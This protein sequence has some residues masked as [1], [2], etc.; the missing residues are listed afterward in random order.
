MLH[1][2]AK[3]L[4]ILRNQRFRRA[5]LGHGVKAGIEFAPLLN[6]LRRYHPQTVIDIGA[7]RGQFALI[8]R[9]AFPQ[10]RLYAFEPLPAPAATFGEVFRGDALVTL[11]P[12]AIGPRSEEARFYVSRQDYSSSLLPISSLQTRLFPGTAEKEQV[13]V[14]VR[15][16]DEVL[17]PA[18]LKPPALLKMDVQGFEHAALEGCRGLLASF[19][20]LYIECS[21]L[22]FYQ[23]QA[24]AQDILD[25]LRPYGF[26]LDGVYNLMYRQGLA[27]QGDFLFAR[28]EYLLAL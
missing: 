16:L 11:Y 2:F 8:A 15:R 24:L 19:A 18:D 7:N 21:F 25:F 6:H 22:E 26:L 3:F 27:V 28:R 1:K 17:T 23:G 9:E 14:Q 10:A 13:T 20:W 5:W 4:A 12:F